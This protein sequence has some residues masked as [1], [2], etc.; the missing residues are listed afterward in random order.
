MDNLQWHF[1]HSDW[2]E[3]L[4][5]QGC[6][7]DTYKEWFDAGIYLRQ[8]LVEVH[9]S[10]ENVSSFFY[11]MQEEGYVTFHKEPNIK[12]SGSNM[13]CVEYAFLKLS[14]NFFEGMN[15]LKQS[16]PPVPVP[17]WEYYD[18]SIDDTP[19]NDMNNYY[20]ERDY[21]I[22]E[23]DYSLYKGNLTDMI[24][25]LE[26]SFQALTAELLELEGNDI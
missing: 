18:R 6:E 11:K 25:Q 8:I 9:N 14:P 23:E 5:F 4:I 12:Y 19:M 26:A 16:F 1:D 13:L 2:T 22:A 15:I 7:W 10:P 3:Y 21:S 24:Q 17:T 20:V